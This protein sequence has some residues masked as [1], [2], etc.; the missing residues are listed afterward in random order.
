MTFSRTRVLYIAAML[1]SGV[2]V[3][4]IALQN[5]GLQEAL[6]PPVIWPIGV[7]LVLDILIGQAAVQGKAEPLTM[8]DRAFGVIGAGLVVT[9]I[10]AS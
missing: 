6:L 10:T 4:L 8:Y 9:L 7:S 2:I 1:V 5:P 3:G